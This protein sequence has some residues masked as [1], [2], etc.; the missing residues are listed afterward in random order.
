MGAFVQQPKT[1]VEAVPGGLAPQPKPIESYPLI[2][3]SPNDPA[4]LTQNLSESNP[5]PWQQYFNPLI[6][7]TN[8]E[9]SWAT[10]TLKR[11]PSYYSDTEGY[12]VGKN[13]INAG[14][15]QL[16]GARANPMST[17]IASKYQRD[18]DSKLQKMR[19]NREMD[20]AVKYSSAIGK[21]GQVLGSAQ[22]L[23][24][25]NY[26]EQF[27]FQQQRQQ[28][29]DQWR[30]HVAQQEAAYTQQILQGIGMALPFFGG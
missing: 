4:Y 24:N 14:A 8:Q 19:T 5:L 21:V 17:A 3:N 27:Q 7:D 16:S 18:T 9:G 22:G 30:Q 20:S 10:Q 6:G 15:P 29:F 11:G 13:P 2:N 1:P 23:A 25:R 26:Q 28:L 12:G